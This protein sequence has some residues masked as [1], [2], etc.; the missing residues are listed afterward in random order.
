MADEQTKYKEA[1][2][3]VVA[4]R[5]QRQ[6]L[7]GDGFLQKSDR[8]FVT[9]IEEK[10]L[11]MVHLFDNPPKDEKAQYERV[12]DTLVDLANYAMMYLQVL[13]NKRK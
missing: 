9:M 6:Q 3:K 10:A 13:Y 2:D 1:L 7:Y 5:L 4:T 8:F 11:R 12:E